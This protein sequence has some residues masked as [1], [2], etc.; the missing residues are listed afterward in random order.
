MD[1]SSNDDPIKVNENVPI[2]EE[3]FIIEDFKKCSES[4][5][6]KL[7]MSFYDRKGG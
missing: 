6:W 2:V 3:R 4:H 1:V 7:M 5:L